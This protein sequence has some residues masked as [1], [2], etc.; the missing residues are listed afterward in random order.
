MTNNLIKQLKKMDAH[1]KED[2]KK[3]KEV[4]DKI[5]ASL[6]IEKEEVIPD[7]MEEAKLWMDMVRD[8]EFIYHEFGAGAHIYFSHEDKECLFATFEDHTD[9]E[10]FLAFQQWLR[11]QKAVVEKSNTII[12]LQKALY[13]K[14]GHHDS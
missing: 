9:A 6:K 13:L 12:E 7:P 8:L 1:R 4:A 3:F 10:G 11:T 2:E 14:R 5:I